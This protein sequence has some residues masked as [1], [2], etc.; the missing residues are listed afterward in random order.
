MSITAQDKHDEFFVLE[1]VC[2]D[3]R[4]AVSV[5]VQG[6]DVAEKQGLA[7]WFASWAGVPVSTWGLS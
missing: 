5:C 6:V 7:V 2:V 3:T 4:G 1:V